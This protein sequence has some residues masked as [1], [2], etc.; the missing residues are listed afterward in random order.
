MNTHTKD[1]PHQPEQATHDDSY[2]GAWGLDPSDEVD[3][4][5]LKRIAALKAEADRGMLERAAEY[6]EA[7]DEASP[8]EPASA[9]P[10]KKA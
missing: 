6:S 8:D 5:R 4:A 10:A 1:Q 2:E 3:Q 7:Y 9:A